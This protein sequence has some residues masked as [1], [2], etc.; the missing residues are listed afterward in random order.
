M[1]LRVTCDVNALCTNSCA[2]LSHLADVQL[3]VSQKDHIAQANDSARSADSVLDTEKDCGVPRVHAS[4]LQ[5]ATSWCQFS[6]GLQLVLDS[7]Q[8]HTVGMPCGRT[9]TQIEC[10]ST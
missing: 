8:L 3:N 4:D 6:C 10:H 1:P 7:W 9:R 5:T 2:I